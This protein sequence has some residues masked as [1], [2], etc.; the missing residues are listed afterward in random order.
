MFESDD[1]DQVLSQLDLPGVSESQIC[2]KDKFGNTAQL[3]SRD[4]SSISKLEQVSFLK[5]NVESNSQ[6]SSENEIS[7]KTI[8]LKRKTINETEISPKHTKRKIINSHFDHTNKRKFPGPAGLLTGTLDETNNNPLCQIELLSQDINSSQNNLPHGLFE[9][10]LW[11]RLLEDTKSIKNINTIKSIKQQAL[12]GNLRRRKAK[13]V[14]AFV[15]S[16]D[17]SAIDP[18]IT[19]RDTTGNIKCTLHRDAWTIFASYI[20]SEYCALVLKNPT[21]LTTGSTFK[22]HYLNITISNIYYIYSTT[23]VNDDEELPNGFVK[24]SNEEFTIVKRE[25]QISDSDSAPDIPVDEMK[26]LEG[27]DFSDIF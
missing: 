2:E 5:N 1:Y 16:I 11:K 12:T 14:Q 23:I 26:E 15:E 20:A 17:R 24:I 6:Y 4:E 10:P 25:K 8:E 9:T 19:L 27:L 13:I 22:N 7:G 21:V 18:L 3:Q